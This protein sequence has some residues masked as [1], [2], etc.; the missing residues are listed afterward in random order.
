MSSVL[1]R[2]RRPNQKSTTPGT[3]RVQRLTSHSTI[4]YRLLLSLLVGIRADEFVRDFMQ[5]DE[6]SVYTL[7][8][9]VNSR[10][11]FQGGEVLVRKHPVRSSGGND[12]SYA[13]EDGYDEDEEEGG[14]E[15]G[16]HSADKPR[17]VPPAPPKRKVAKFDMLTTTIARYTPEKGG[18]V[19][20]LS[21]HEHGLHSLARGRRDSLVVEFWP[22]ADAPPGSKRPS[23]RDARPLPRRDAEL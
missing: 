13:E 16:A 1:G 3:P 5:R 21:N 10:N 12:D 17:D 7:N 2:S 18:G 8:L 22:Y 20:I 23:I 11:K 15:G 19:L 6:H 4:F 9:L 14:G